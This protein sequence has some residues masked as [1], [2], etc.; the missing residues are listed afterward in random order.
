MLP[1]VNPTE[2]KA[3]KKL[4]EHYGVMK[5][6]PMTDLFRRDPGRFARF[7]LGFED[8]TVD[9]SKNIVTRET[10][11]LL[12]GLARECRLKE[13]VEKMFSG[14]RINETEN[15]AVL[16]VA[17]RNRSNRPMR[18]D[19][20]DVMPEVNEVLSRMERFSGDILSGKWRGYSGKGITDIVNIGIGGSDLGP[21]MVA[22][23]LKPYWKPGVR[24]H[25]VSN[26]DGA[27]LAETLKELSPESTLFIVASKTFTTQETMTNART[28]RQLVPRYCRERKGCQEPFCCRI[29]QRR[30]GE[31]LRNRPREYVSILGLGGRAVFA[32]VR[33]RPFHCLHHRI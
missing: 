15:R 7:S 6:R 12:F 18:V 20:K 5:S 30:G 24:A 8:L 9:Y 21:A 10:M 22:E 32:L 4:R 11:R 23:A 28:A 16:H 27:H 14:D 1:K 13:A 33:H 31:G 25:F 3:W 26:V 19:G 29:H 17:L 2:T